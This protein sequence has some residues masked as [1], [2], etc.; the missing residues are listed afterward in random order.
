MDK[1][2]K[3]KALR[4]N[5]DKTKPQAEKKTITR[6]ETDDEYY[7]RTRDTYDKN[8]DKFDV[9]EDRKDMRTGEPIDR[10]T[11]YLIDLKDRKPPR[12]DVE[13]EVTV[14]GVKKPS[15]SNK[16]VSKPIGRDYKKN[17]APKSLEKQ[18]RKKAIRR[19]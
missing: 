10:S 6:P 16:K 9:K 18:N 4:K 12:K 17:I 2:R 11:G 8:M 3:K 15:G 1:P 14:K 7:K 13:E 5:G 19:S